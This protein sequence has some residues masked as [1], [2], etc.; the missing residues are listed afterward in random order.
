M[1]VIDRVLL[2]D[3]DIVDFSVRPDPYTVWAPETTY[4]RGRRVIVYDGYNKVYESMYPNTGLYPPDHLQGEQPAWYFVRPINLWSMLGEIPDQ[5]TQGDDEIYV[6]VAPQ[7]KVDAVGLHGL[8]A[9]SVTVETLDE[10]DQVLDTQALDL[11]YSHLL[12]PATGATSEGRYTE[13]IFLTL[14]VPLGARIRVSIKDIGSR[15]YCESLVFGQCRTLGITKPSTLVDVIDPSEKVFD[16]FGRAYVNK[17]DIVRGV[18]ANVVIP[19]NRVDYAHRVL[20]RLRATPT[21]WITAD[22]A[23]L[24]MFYGM[25]KEAEIVLDTQTTGL[26]RLD[27][28]PIY[29]QP[30]KPPVKPLQ[31]W[32]HLTSKPYPVVFSDALSISHVS[33]LK[34]ELANTLF[35][36]KVNVANVSV[37]I[38]EF[39]QPLRKVNLS[40]ALD[41]SHVLTDISDF[42]EI[43]KK[44][45]SR[46]GD[47]D[48]D[49]MNVN[50]VTVDFNEF[51]LALLRYEIISNQ[52]GEADIGKIN[53]SNVGITGGSLE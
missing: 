6:T 15:V 38:S 24:S 8:E 40:E 50:N 39:R 48:I 13:A 37:E 12:D 23:P 29:Y 30:I 34:S 52:E 42:R 16:T 14:N 53:V 27:V 43:L 18:S 17:R 35:T 20:A 41:V 36:E 28:L 5:R 32:H 45:S 1:R 31:K 19:K 21:T 47:I 3:S 22:R 51:R 33:A 11:E 49:S 44:I 25:Y 9:K 26:C 4:R 2:K 46:D 7:S 10:S